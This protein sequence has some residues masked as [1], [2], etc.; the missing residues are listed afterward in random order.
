MVAYNHKTWMDCNKWIREWNLKDSVAQNLGILE[1]L[2]SLG[3]STF[4]L[5]Y[6]ERKINKIFNFFFYFNVPQME[7]VSTQGS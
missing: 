5:G 6:I 7:N 4:L 3:G 1:K 2:T